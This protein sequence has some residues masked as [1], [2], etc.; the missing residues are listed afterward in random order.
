[1]CGQFWLPLE[2]ARQCKAKIICCLQ[3]FHFQNLSYFQTISFD[4]TLVK[5]SH[6]DFNRCKNQFW[7]FP[8]V[9]H[10]ILEFSAV[11]LQFHPQTVSSVF[12]AY[13]KQKENKHVGGIL[14]FPRPAGTLKEVTIGSRVMITTGL[15]IA[16]TGTTEW[17]ISAPVGRAGEQNTEA[18]SADRQKQE[19]SRSESPLSPS[20]GDAR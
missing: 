5:M 13:I 12:P 9:P 15:D 20:S 18:S 6:C 17:T 16:P 3:E 1:M 10:L 19:I 4:I 8:P 14:V 2:T 7:H 11:L